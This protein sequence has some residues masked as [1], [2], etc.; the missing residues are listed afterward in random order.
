[1]LVVISIIALLIGIL[2]PALTQ[3][4]KMARKGV[5]ASNQ[6]QIGY[7]LGLYSTENKDYIPR[8]GKHPYRSTWSKGYHYQWPRLFFQY[9]FEGRPLVHEGDGETFSA[10]NPNDSNWARYTFH[11]VAAYRDPDHPNQNHQIHYVNNGLML[12]PQG[13]IARDG[14]HPTAQI[15]EFLRPDSSM[16][17][18]AFNDDSDNE[19][20]NIVYNGYHSEGI[21]ALYDTFTVDHITGPEDGANGWIGNVA[22]IDSDRHQ[23]G[24]N[25]LFIDTHVE[26]RTKETLK[27]ID[28]WDDRTYNENFGDKW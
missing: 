14:R 7:A 27:D 16:F 24:S 28:S 9:V 20:F 10:T 12:T 3:A 8:E 13:N 5:C 18:T 11:Q 4:R 22:R 1:M 15:T 17:L 23:T 26:L 2:L 19:I 21:D 25:A 6:K